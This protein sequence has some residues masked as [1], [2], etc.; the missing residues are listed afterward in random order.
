[1]AAAA[2]ALGISLGVR[3]GWGLYIAPMTLDLGWSFEAFGLAIAIQNLLWGATQP[4]AGMLA[5]RYGSG[6][7]I[8]VGAAFY[9]L[10][11]WG[12]S[13][14]VTPVALHLT[15]GVLIGIGMSGAG[16]SVIYSA[17]ARMVEPSRRT[18]ALA[19]V[20]AMSGI[21]PLLLPKISEQLIAGYGWHLA[22]VA[23]AVFALL[24][25]GLASQLT[26]RSVVDAGARSQNWREALSE[27]GG[28]QGYILLT[29]GFF[30]CGFH[31]TFIGTHLPGFIAWC[32][33]PLHVAGS[34]LALIGAANIAGT[35]LAGVL[36]RRYRQKNLLSLI[37]LGRAVLL[38]GLIVAPRTEWTIYAFSAVFGLLWLSTVPLTSGL[39]ARMFGAQ[40]L[41]MLFG[42]VFFSHQIGAFLGAWL[43]GRM[44]DLTGNYDA[45]WYASVALGL[46]AAVLHWPIRDQPA[47]R[48]EAAQPA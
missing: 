24:M 19:M 21:G 36:S 45:M 16:I 11:V 47:E 42:L 15:A 18:H 3:Q 44:Y 5:D 31:V 25:V 46:L 13:M 38:A 39:V 40:H 33:L 37:Y 32:G 4:V 28:K 22:L 30:V 14:A 6:R 10:G 48:G 26:G 2:A 20:S 8:G 1:M 9:G 7:I 41:G 27:A 23:T 43:G 29:F 17:V 34:A 12:M 35:W